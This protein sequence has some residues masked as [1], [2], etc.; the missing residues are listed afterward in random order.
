MDRQIY[1]YEVTEEDLK[2]N[3]VDR[4][5]GIID[6]MKQE[7]KMFRNSLRIICLAYNHIPDELHTIPKFR[8]WIRK[9]AKLRPFFLYFLCLDLETPVHVLGC[10]GDAES[11]L[12]GERVSMDE[13]ER[14]NLTQLDFPLVRT[15]IHFDEDIYLQMKRSI[16]QLC[17]EIGDPEGEAELIALLEYHR[18]KSM[19]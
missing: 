14:R 13:I 6:R 9:V 16:Q 5:I 7:G 4:L 19:L 17:K 12:I 3:R 2:F 18:P 8:R 11:I 10:L 1:T 15:T